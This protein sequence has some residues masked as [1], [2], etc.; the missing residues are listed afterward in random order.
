MANLPLTDAIL[1]YLKHARA[2]K[3]LI[4]FGQHSKRRVLKPYLNPLGSVVW[5]LKKLAKKNPDVAKVGW[6]QWDLKSKYTKAKFAKLVAKRAGK[7]GRSTE[8]HK[9]R[10]L[11]GMEVAKRRGTHIGA[12]AKMTPEVMDKITIR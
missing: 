6:G 10:T 7:G 1:E 2:R 4:K 8:E 12:P 5:A 3:R 9:R 11:D